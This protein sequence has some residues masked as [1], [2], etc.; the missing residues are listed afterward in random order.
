MRDIISLIFNIAYKIVFNYYIAYDLSAVSIAVVL[1]K[2]EATTD[3]LE[4]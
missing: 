2:S 3:A 1:V 4:I